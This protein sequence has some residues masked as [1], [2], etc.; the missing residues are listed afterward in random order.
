[1][2]M[3]LRRLADSLGSFVAMLLLVALLATVLVGVVTRA[4]NTPFI[5]TDEMSR[6][7]MV[8]LAVIGWI[9]ACRRRGHIRVRFFRDLLPARARRLAEVA[10]QLAVAVFGVLLV[11][12]GR[13][14]VI[15]NV[16]LQATTLPLSMSWLYLPICLAG[17]VT[18]AQAVAEI[19]QHLNGSGPLPTGF[20]EEPGD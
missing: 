12:F 19:C 15:R 8:W 13:E 10:M 5:W 18:T 2:L 9:L 4:F 14:L 6:L 11:W 16:D 1:M 20:S 7:L 17:L 3:R